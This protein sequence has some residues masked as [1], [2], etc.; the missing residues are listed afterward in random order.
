MQI[1]NFKPSDGEKVAELIFDTVHS[2]CAADYTRE[3]LDAWIPR[4]MDIKQFT[5][6]LKNCLNLVAERDGRIA[7]FINVGR[8]GYINRLFTR[9]DC[10]R[11]GIATALLIEAEK[12][13]VSRGVRVMTLEASATALPFYLARGFAKTGVRRKVKNGEVFYNTKMLKRLMG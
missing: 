9:K 3:Q 7:G 5:R 8:D 2:V 11:E 10:L 12:W 6:S 1:R 13:C 4:N